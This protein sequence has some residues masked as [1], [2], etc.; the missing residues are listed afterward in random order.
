MPACRGRHPPARRA[1]GISWRLGAY[2]VKNLRLAHGSLILDKNYGST[3]PHTTPEYCV[4]YLSGATHDSHCSDAASCF[5]IRSTWSKGRSRCQMHPTL[6]KCNVIARLIMR[7]IIGMPIALVSVPESRNLRDNAPLADSE[8][9]HS[10][11]LPST[12]GFYIVLT[13]Y[14]CTPYIHGSVSSCSYRVKI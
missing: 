11:V 9:R 12:I 3:Q 13:T 8:V 14:L 4:W 6:L 10:V 2:S 1:V 7:A 5:F